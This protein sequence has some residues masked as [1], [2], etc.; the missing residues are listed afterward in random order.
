MLVQPE[1]DL[2]WSIAR[3]L[4]HVDEDPLV[5]PKHIARKPQAMR[6]GNV[7]LNVQ[8]FV[9][10][11]RRQGRSQH[12]LGRLGKR[13]GYLNYGCFLVNFN[14]P[15]RQSERGPIDIVDVGK[16]GR[17]WIYTQDSLD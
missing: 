3:L 13:V 12:R 9:G 7:E 4:K 1:L 5:R 10:L 14:R 11:V 16:G 8:A 6:A 15:G 2:G 17:S